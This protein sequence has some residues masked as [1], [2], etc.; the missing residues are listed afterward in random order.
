VSRNGSL[1]PLRP[2]GVATLAALVLGVGCAGAACV[3]ASPANAATIPVTNTNDSGAGSLREAIISANADGAQDDI[4]VQATGTVNLLSAL[5]DLTSEIDIAGPGA[6]ELTI[7]RSAGGDYRILTIAGSGDVSVSGVSLADGSV[8]GITATGGA[9]SNAGVLSLNQVV[10]RDSAAASLGPNFRANAFGGGIYSTGSLDITASTV[11]D[12]VAV[13]TTNDNSAEVDARGGGIDNA[14]GTVTISG[15]TVSGNRATGAA[16]NG[17]AFI[18]VASAVGGGIQ[19]D[20]TLT[21]TNT[22]VSGNTAEHEAPPG[23]NAGNAGGGIAVQVNST[24]T[25]LRSVTLAFNRSQTGANL[26]WTNS[27]TVDVQ[28]TIFGEPLG[29]GLN[30]SATS[31]NTVIDQGHNLE[32]GTSCGFSGPTD[33]Q[34]AD[35][36]LQPF[37]DNGGPTETHA[38]AKTSPAVDQ[39]TVVAAASDQRGVPRPVD[40]AGI[41]NGSGDGSDIGAFE[42]ILPALALGPPNVDF[43]SATVGTISA[44][45]EITATNTGGATLDLGR[46]QVVGIHPGDFLIS[47]DACSFQ[48]LGPADACTAQVRFAP[49]AL[50]IRAATLQVPS[51]ADTSPDGVALTGRGIPA[52]VGGG[53]RPA[54]ATGTRAMALKKCKKKRGKARRRCRKG[55]KKLP[56]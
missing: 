43:D 30:C 3:F 13:A 41:P 46:L 18:S 52:P 10:V 12:N 6:D 42:L 50:G 36:L 39:G 1:L 29:G 49:S 51:N 27:A 40:F 8:T 32:D 55:A 53:D 9:I 5:P 54:G 33:Q 45:V 38:L 23:A 16:P 11:R 2:P 20:G 37:A 19:N 17:G 4:D 47:H 56:V 34:N 15:S 31:T 21:A 7:R 25:T 24:Q 35:P 44:P 48:S 14:G 22:T 26:A 28:N